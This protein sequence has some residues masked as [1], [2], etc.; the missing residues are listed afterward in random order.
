MFSVM[1]SEGEARIFSAMSLSPPPLLDFA[2]IDALFSFSTAA[3][4]TVHDHDPWRVPTAFWMDRMRLR[5][6]LRTAVAVAVDSAGDIYVATNRK[7]PPSAQRPPVSKPSYSTVVAAR[8]QDASQ[9]SPREL[10]R[11]D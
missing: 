1:S 3:F 2:A 11:V 9:L 5:L 6:L 8:T 4:A 7:E 10:E